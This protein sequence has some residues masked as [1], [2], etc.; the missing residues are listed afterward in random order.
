MRPGTVVTAVPTAG[1]SGEY[2]VPV[3]TLSPSADSAAVDGLSDGAIERLEAV[4]FDMDGT[5]IDSEPM[6]WA[7][8]DR[9]ASQL[10]GTLTHELR[11]ATTGVS[12]PTSVTMLLEHIG[13]DHDPEAAEELL[14]TL[15]GELFADEVRWQP[16]AEQLIDGIRAA[17]LKVALVTNSPR[18]VVD[19]A[20]GLLGDHRF[21]VTVAGDEVANGKPEPDPYLIAMDSL[22]LP[23]A[24]CLA[25][26]DSLSGTESAIA[27]GVAVLVVPSATTVPDGPGRIFAASLLG[28]TVEELR[29]IHREFRRA[30]FRPQAG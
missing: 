3:T 29:H 24:A 25:V 18:S 30:G 10:G 22:G 8:M 12:I 11:E 2:P 13:S 26:E 15:T 5:L 14:L 23:A 1:V 27:A 19:Q 6:W 28:A 7:A 17:G 21:D 20:L 16:G 9:V 4:L